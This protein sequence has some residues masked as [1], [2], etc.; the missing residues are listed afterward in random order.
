MGGLTFE[1]GIFAAR[2]FIQCR[3]KLRFGKEYSPERKQLPE[4]LRI[5]QDSTLG[6]RFRSPRSH[7][8]P[9]LNY[10]M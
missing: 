6:T 7:A 9:P 10:A 4:A 5:S 2:V 3:H 8:H 1:S